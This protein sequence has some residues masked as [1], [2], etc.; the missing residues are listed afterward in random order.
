M[1]PRN[2]G[3]GMTFVQRLPCLGYPGP[4]PPFHWVPT[5]TGDEKVRS[6]CGVEFSRHY[7]LV[8]FRQ[9]V[10]GVRLCR[11]CQGHLGRLAWVFVVLRISVVLPA[12]R[13]AGGPG[14]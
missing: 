12:A 6:A 9:D 7:Y 1:N 2:S 3:L 5:D 13:T 14:G 8:R 11:S 10:K 4:K